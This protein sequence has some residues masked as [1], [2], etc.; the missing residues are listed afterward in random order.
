MTPIVQ[1]QENCGHFPWTRADLLAALAI[2]VAGGL[3][4]RACWQPGV[5]SQWDMLRGI[6]RGLALEQAWQAGI[7]YPRL[8]PPW[9]Y[10]YGAPLFEFYAPAASYLG[11]FFRFVGLGWVEAS[12]AV[13]TA[14]LLLAGL[15][16]YVYARWLFADRR[17]GLLA[18]IVYA[19][20]PYLLINLYERGA[21]AE[22]LGLALL[23][24]LFFVA[25]R[26][27]REG[28]RGWLAASAALVTLL[29]LTHNI[30]AFVA[31]PLL[32]LYLLSIAWR[33]RDASGLRRLAGAFALGLALSAFFW[34]PA[35]FERGA[36][37]IETRM[38]SRELLASQLVAP[39]T[40]VQRQ[41][42][43]DYWGDQRFHL[44]L[45]QALIGA[46]ALLALAAY[47]AMR[48]PRSGKSS[49]LALLAVV[50]LALLALQL[51]A[52]LPFWDRAPLV[53]FVQFP[54]RLLGIVSLSVALFAG[55]ALTLARGRL[56]WVLLAGALAL[57]G[58]GSL[59]N[60]DPARSSLWEMV[61]SQEITDARLNERAQ[62]GY[63]LFTDY[64]PAGV[65]VR[66]EQLTAPRP[67]GSS[68]PALAG[69]APRLQVTEERL[70]RLTLQVDAAAP[71][72]LRLHRFY[73]PG[74]QITANGRPVPVRPTGELGLVTAD[75]P[76]G[77]YTATARFGE[78]PLRMALDIVSALA[79]VALVG[80]LTFNRRTR[81]ALAFVGAA[82]LLV[83]LLA[84][85]N[86]SFTERRIAPVALSVGFEDKVTLLGYHLP[87]QSY[88]AGDTIPLRLYWQ[89][90]RGP[91]EDL[92][93]FAHVVR[94]P[95]G[96][97]VAQHDSVP[98]QNYSPT[99]RWEPGEI[100]IDEQQIQL[101]P[102]APP[103]T[104]RLLVGVYRQDPVQ[105]LRAAG[106][107]EILPGD[108]VAVAEITVT[109]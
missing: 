5:A 103:G 67:G 45:W 99:T 107:A 30:T 34:V 31:L 53:R 3:A 13:F 68:E 19:L 92:K 57:V 24:W 4:A 11:L 59:R 100:V 80:L 40:L 84:W 97:K 50:T 1:D 16:M 27:L 42:A 46:A 49:G 60:L 87:R 36:T 95:D 78:T 79:L 21:A 48:R 15:G 73:Y 86:G 55:A 47:A 64:L 7:L 108:R 89:A 101:P 14:A 10:T 75:M 96:D 88:R 43:F 90:Q 69:P 85:R 62:W 76:A 9:N 22:S 106:S 104:Y 83:A 77:A 33:Q 82:L 58:F 105:N 41:L 51:Q 12:K 38:T 56:G 74:W 102:G 25:H 20:S 28:G 66:A 98:I 23:P 29:M 93:V 6:Y 61:S 18:A 109:E 65:T 2:V 72:T 26:L 52:A 17:A 35:L 37:Q 32:A 81:P 44:S 63:A 71:F 94:P 70:A 54:W 91:A 39:T 8:F